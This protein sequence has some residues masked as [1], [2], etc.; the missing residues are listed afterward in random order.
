M[1]EKNTHSI[2]ETIKKKLNK[3]DSKT[4]KSSKISDAAAEFEYIAAPTKPA[5]QSS[6]MDDFLNDPQEQKKKALRDSNDFNLDDFNEKLPEEKA[7]TP[8]VSPIDNSM[9]EMEMTQPEILAPEFS[10]PEPAQ[11]NIAPQQSLEAASAMDEDDIEDYEDEVEF[12]EENNEAQESE[13]AEEEEPQV[14][15]AAKND[16]L[17]FENNGSDELNFADQ[18]EQNPDPLNLEGENKLN[19]EELETL[20]E[21]PHEKIQEVVEPLPATPSQAEAALDAEEEDDALDFSDILDSENQEEA[22]AIAQKIENKNTTSEKELTEEKDS[23]DMELAELDKELAMKEDEILQ[24]PAE[25]K[26]E[27]AHDDIDLE[28]EQEIF[29]NK[30]KV[31]PQFI[32]PEPINL[33]EEV[34]KSEPVSAA[35]SLPP[36][37]HEL[38]DDLDFEMSQELPA[39]PN[40]QNKILPFDMTTSDKSDSRILNEKTIMQTSDS[41][42]KLVDAKNVMSGISNFSQSPA[43]VELAT[44]LLEP[45][46]EK[47]L[48]EHLGEL[49]EKI[50]REEIKKIIPK[51]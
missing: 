9:M 16:E 35:I 43:L 36:I 24:H 32:A 12:N 23:Y 25:V 38:S 22:Q 14:E 47:W 21:M 34:K 2:L 4:E 45:K 48:N 7:P 8:P 17:T 33:V 27:A 44:H 1:A 5:V 37:D 26:K 29:A 18:E 6:E 28:F 41:I 10:A 50:V 51:E 13:E 15:E 49:V 39:Q 42:R 20:P 40:Q 3:F 30:E 31:A 19:I 11:E 46:L